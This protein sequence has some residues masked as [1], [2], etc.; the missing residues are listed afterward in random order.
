[1]DKKTLESYQSLKRLLERNNRKIE[2]EKS[3]E[4]SVVSGKVKSSM[5]EFPFIET[6][7]SVQMDKPDEVAASNR[8][9]EKWRIENEN[10]EKQIKLIEE[11]I[12]GIKEIQTKEILTY[13]YLDGKPIKEVADILGYTKGRISQI[14]TRCLKD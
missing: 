4:L 2:N 13:R 10:A 7:V 1:M 12:N 3:K 14:I 11:F 6:R 5:D 8:K 9:I